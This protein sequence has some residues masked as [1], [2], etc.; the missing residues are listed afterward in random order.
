MGGC[1]MPA[2][3]LTA[4]S[5]FEANDVI[6]PDRLS[7]RD[8]GCPGAGGFMFRLAETGKRL[9]NIRDQSAD[10]VSTHLISSNI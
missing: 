8:G 6:A 1:D 9:M 7:Y 5:T 10:L 2:K 3:R 4:P